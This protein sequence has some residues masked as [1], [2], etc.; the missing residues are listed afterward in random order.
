MRGEPELR[1][2]QRGLVVHR[3][4]DARVRLHEAEELTHEAGIVASPDPP[5]RERERLSPPQWEAVKAVH[6]LAGLI[7]RVPGCAD[8]VDVA[9]AG[10]EVA[11]MVLR[12]FGVPERKWYPH[13]RDNSAAAVRPAGMC[14]RRSFA[15]IAATEPPRVISATR[16][17]A[18]FSWSTVFAGPRD[19][20]KRSYGAYALFAL[21]ISDSGLRKTTWP[22]SASNRLSPKRKASPLACARSRGVSRV[23]SG[24]TD[25]IAAV[26]CARASASR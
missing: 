22:W 5:L 21:F 4:P 3:H 23:S 25:S 17:H 16:R 15:S 13:E 10:P 19:R 7:G 2:E 20:P 8:P 12:D 6:R 14:S 11:R 1:L 26:P 9:R 24:A 18:F